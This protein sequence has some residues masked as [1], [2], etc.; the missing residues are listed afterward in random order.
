[1]IIREKVR[2]HSAA[3]RQCRQGSYCTNLVVD[4]VRRVPGGLYAH[5]GKANPRS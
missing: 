3:C 2:E 5:W 4:K 1:M